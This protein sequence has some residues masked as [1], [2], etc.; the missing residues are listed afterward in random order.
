M[1]RSLVDYDDDGGRSRAHAE[2]ALPPSDFAY[3]LQLKAACAYTVDTTSLTKSFF[4]P[5]VR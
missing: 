1:R 5:T 3:N 2:T 4:L